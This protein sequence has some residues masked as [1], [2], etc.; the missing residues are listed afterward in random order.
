MYNRLVIWGAMVGVA[1]M[2]ALCENQEN[3]VSKPLEWGSSN[4]P[5]L[6]ITQAKERV[7]A[8][9][10]GKNIDIFCELAKNVEKMGLTDDV[11]NR[12][13]RDYEERNVGSRL[14]I[15]QSKPYFTKMMSDPEIRESMKEGDKIHQMYQ[16][17]WFGVI[18]SLALMVGGAL[19]K[20]SNPTRVSSLDRHAMEALTELVDETSQQGF[21][22]KS[23]NYFSHR[24]EYLTEKENFKFSNEMEKVIKILVETPE[25]QK[26]VLEEAKWAGIRNNDDQIYRNNSERKS[27]MVCTRKLLSEILTFNE[28]LINEKDKPVNMDDAIKR[29]QINM[30]A[31]M[32]NWSLFQKCYLSE[33]EEQRIDNAEKLTLHKVPREILSDEKRKQSN[34]GQAY[35]LWLTG[36]ILFV[37][38]WMIYNTWKSYPDKIE[39][40][41]IKAQAKEIY[42]VQQ[43]FMENQTN[44]KKSSLK[45][46]P[47]QIKQHN[48]VVRSIIQGRSQN[49]R[50]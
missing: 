29:L 5:S 1:S 3:Q 27:S 50:D 26:A 39:E 8:L 33:I 24:L 44:Q 47:H 49:Q 45:G 30:I 21:T 15:E 25:I 46:Q 28:K 42:E 32:S 41:I 16:W 11:W 9:Q 6:S 35:L 2:M 37:S 20:V 18:S 38:S 17:V 40:K 10:I 7:N 43:N 19:K 12:F 36:G 34:A 22:K 23:W 31:L 13:V 4:S 14:Y 48:R